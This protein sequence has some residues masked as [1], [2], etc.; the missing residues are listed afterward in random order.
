MAFMVKILVSINTP[1]TKNATPLDVSF[2]STLYCFA[3][4]LE[5]ERVLS[6]GVHV[7]RTSPTDIISKKRTQGQVGRFL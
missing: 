7:S 6:W 3:A 5:Q 1:S 4:C 2:I